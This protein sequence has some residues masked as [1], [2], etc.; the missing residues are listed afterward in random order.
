[1]TRP[2]RNVMVLVTVMLSAHVGAAQPSPGTEGET[3]LAAEQAFAAAAAQ[4]DVVTALTAMFAP[5][6]IMPGPPGVLHR[7]LSAVAASLRSNPD[8]VE[9]RVEWTA[10]RLGLSADGQHG[11]T[12]GFMTLRKKD[13][14]AMPLK[15]MAYWVKGPSGWRV[16][17]YKRARRPEGEVST[18][19]MAPLLPAALVPVKHDAA[20]LDALRASLSAAEKAFSDEAQTIG[21]GAAFTKWGSDTAV[22]MGGPTNAGYVVGPVAI[23][24][25]VGA[26]APGPTSPV[27]WSTDVAL[28]ASS[29]DLGIS[30]GYIRS[31]GKPPEGAPPNGSPFFTIW[32]RPSATAPWRYIAE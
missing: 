14:S 8:N 19:P 26:G 32:H 28:V 18:T 30:F 3:L 17:G 15:Y 27:E 9:G 23:G 25:S 11:F 31:H 22:N 7:G 16:A 6:V 12:F 10:I 1:M 29:G 20:H 5:D 2:T 21:L 4:A 13:G 24:K